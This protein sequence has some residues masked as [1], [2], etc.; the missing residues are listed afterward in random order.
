LFNRFRS[1][2]GRSRSDSMCQH[3]HV[4]EVTR[5]TWKSSTNQLSTYLHVECPSR[6]PDHIIAVAA[7]THRLPLMPHHRNGC[8][9][10]DGVVRAEP[11]PS[12]SAWFARRQADHG[13]RRGVVLTWKCGEVASMIYYTEIGKPC[14]CTCLCMCCSSFVFPAFV[15]TA[16][17]RPGPFFSSSSS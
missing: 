7:C 12:A 17:F 3:F 14:R 13:R 2:G 9:G 6:S 15:L 11:G 10:C 1:D 4:S 16:F 5:E 8:T